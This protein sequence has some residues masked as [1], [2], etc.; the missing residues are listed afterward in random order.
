MQLGMRDSRKA[1]TESGL[2][3]EVARAKGHRGQ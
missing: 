3:E 1:V 2:S